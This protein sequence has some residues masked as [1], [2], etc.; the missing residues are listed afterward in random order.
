MSLRKLLV[1]HSNHLVSNVVKRQILSEFND[2]SIIDASS[3]EEIAVIFQ[4]EHLDLIL[5][6]FNLANISSVNF[7]KNINSKLPIAQTGTIAIIEKDL[8]KCVNFL[9][10]NGIGS[11]LSFPFK[12]IELK[13]KV[14]SVCDA[15]LKRVH[16]RFNI[17]NTTTIL[18]CPLEDIEGQLINISKGG[19][20]C[21]FFY[22]Q[23]P[24]N[25]FITNYVTIKIPAPNGFFEIK[26][27]RC[28]VSNLNVVTWSSDD[29]AAYLRIAFTF[30]KITEQN[31]SSL[32]EL[33]EMAKEI[34]ARG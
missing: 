34:Q 30:T 4:K 23:Q 1:Y 22:N 14:N 7:F 29:R 2:I 24:F 18:H 32:E 31:K 28:K 6:E 11:Y 15:R 33:I 13:D 17:P 20:L 5:I 8:K 26:K 27:I 21:E 9:S 12:T 19:M 3:F 16:D 10:D 25:L